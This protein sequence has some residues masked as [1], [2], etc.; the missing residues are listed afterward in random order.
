[1]PRGAEA[2]KGSEG[3]KERLVCS[4]RRRKGGPVQK[5][6]PVVEKECAPPVNKNGKKKG[7]KKGVDRERDPLR[8]GQSP[9]RTINGRKSWKRG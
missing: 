5:G 9:E 2:T 6:E 8:E 7:K 1:M 3:V 4:G